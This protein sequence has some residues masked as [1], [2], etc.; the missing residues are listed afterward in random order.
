MWATHISRRVPS[1]LLFAC[2]LVL[3]ALA[4]D[5]P[6]ILSR[7]E[8]G[9]KSPALA[10][11]ANEPVRLTIHHTATTPNAGRSL[12]EK[13]TSLQR[14][15]QSEER[16]ADG[17]LKVA[18]GDIPYHYYID[19]NGAIGEAREEK[20]IGDS[21][22]DYDLDGHVGIVLEGNFEKEPPTPMQ[23]ESLVAL[24]AQLARQHGIDPEA[25]DTHQ[26]YAQTA[27]PGKHLIALLP[28]IRSDVAARLAE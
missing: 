14:F 4:A 20:F 21:N 6:S 7:A 15:S 13:L 5:S 3:P 23:V 27:C 1:A 24:L 2:L 22:T 17:R 19:L 18:W 26:H 8:W 12:A 9:A 16:L 11:E 10:M 25:I 28:D